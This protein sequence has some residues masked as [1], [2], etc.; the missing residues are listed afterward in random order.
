[1][2]AISPRRCHSTAFTLIELLVVIAVIAILAGLLFAAI[3]QISSKR[4]K[5]VA[6]A[7][8]FQIQTA[9]GAYKAHYGVYPPDNSKS[10]YVSPLYFELVGTTN[11][12]TS[13]VTLDGRDSTLQLDLPKF[14]VSGFVNS[15][16]NARGTDDRPPAINFL[17]EFKRSQIGSSN[18]VLVL[19]C[20]EQLVYPGSKEN[21]AW[22]YNSSNPTNNPESYDLW[23]DLYF[24]GKTNRISNWSKQPVF[25]Y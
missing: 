21:C 2:K 8:L 11:S 20:S 5:A 1:M 16:V 10:V 15:S 18:G 24:G 17:K 25:V 12:G 13:Y 23:V 7:E 22:R 6:Y 4:S 19:V 9:I 14:N 3:P